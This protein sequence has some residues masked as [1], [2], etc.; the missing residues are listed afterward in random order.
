MTEQVVAD[1]VDTSNVIRRS[2]ALLP[3]QDTI[4]E[5]YATEIAEAPGRE[6]YSQAL[7]RIISEW[8][9]QRKLP[10]DR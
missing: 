7:R 10:T 2:V 3:E 9:R 8:S 4:I 6:N 5:R 1:Q